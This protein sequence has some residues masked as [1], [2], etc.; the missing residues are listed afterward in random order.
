MERTADILKSDYFESLYIFHQECKK[1]VCFSLVALTRA[2]QESQST[3]S[4]I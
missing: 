4:P 1:V 2:H 3:Q